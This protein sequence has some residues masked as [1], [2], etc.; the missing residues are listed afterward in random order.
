M[1][2]TDSIKL[3]NKIIELYLK[4]AT[5]LPDDIIAALKK[6]TQ[7]ESSQ[8][9]ET[10]SILLQNIA[11]AKKESRPICQDTGTPFFYVSR[12]VYYLERELSEIIEK[13][14]MIATKEAILRPNAV[15]PV[16]DKNI[17]N[18]PV[19][20]F[21]ESVGSKLKIDL[22]LKGGGSENISAVYQLPDKEINADRNLEG[23]RKC[24]LNSIFK[25]QGKGCPPYVI[26]VAIGGN[27]EEVSAL[28]KKQLLRNLKDKNSDL[29]LATLEKRLL[30]EANQLGI[31]PAGMGGNTTVLGI[32]IAS[33]PRHPAS[34]FVGVSFSCWCLRR[35]SLCVG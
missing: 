11:L 3:I 23:V 21:E 26:G 14:T 32:K 4:T 34:Y 33:V 15:D 5:E 9:K 18:K 27:I 25:A 22:I 16:L 10:L 1:K 31:G 35:Q 24:V 8:S 17:G 12:P 20:H 13:A 2:T 19:I 6:T 30:K 28:S 29:I 7:N